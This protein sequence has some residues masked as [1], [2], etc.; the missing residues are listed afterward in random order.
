MH[1]HIG[2]KRKQWFSRGYHGYR[3]C[4]W[5]RTHNGDGVAQ[6]GGHSPANRLLE[7]CTRGLLY[8]IEIICLL[9]ESAPTK[10]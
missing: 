10:G 1:T 2:K 6:D 4:S 8:D 7:T 5:T 9:T 3:Y